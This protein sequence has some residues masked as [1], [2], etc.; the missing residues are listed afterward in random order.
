MIEST[1]TTLLV[2]RKRRMVFDM[3]E[4]MMLVDDAQR[5]EKCR[6]NTDTGGHTGFA[7]TYFTLGVHKKWSDTCQIRG[8]GREQGGTLRYAALF[9]ELV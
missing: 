7:T 9:Q 5:Q 4:G 1:A 2:M 3:K 6:N 8:L